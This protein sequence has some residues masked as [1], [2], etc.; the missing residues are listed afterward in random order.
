MLQLVLKCCLLSVVSGSGSEL[1]DMFDKTRVNN[2]CEHFQLSSTWTRCG[3]IAEELLV[4]QLLRTLNSLIKCR[5]DLVFSKGV[6]FHFSYNWFNEICY[7]LV[8]TSVVDSLSPI[9]GLGLRVSSQN[10]LRPHLV[11]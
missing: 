10:S 9:D 5:S 4:E 11:E 3:T 8:V 7:K 6:K 2:A 1:S